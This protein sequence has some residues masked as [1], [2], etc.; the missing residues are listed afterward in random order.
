MNWYLPSLL[1]LLL[2]GI[3][4]FFYKV[5][6]ERRCSTAWVTFSFM[7][8]VMV[9]ST[10]LFFIQERQEANLGYLLA[11][12]FVNAAAFLMATV[13][14]IEAL[15][16]VPAHIA[17]TLIRMNVVVAAVFSLIYFKDHLSAVQGAGLIL[18]VAA[19]MILAWRMRRLPPSGS[20]DHRLRGAVFIGVAL[21][22]GATASISSKFA[23]LH[24][25]KLAFMAVSYL[26]GMI[27]SLGI[28]RAVP[29]AGKNAPNSQAVCLGIAMGLFNLGGFYA[30][31]LAL[32]TGP[33]SIIA[34]MVGMHFVISILLSAAIYRE[35]ISPAGLLG[36]LLTII[37]IV[38][39]RA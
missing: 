24:T 2:L 7:S 6:A 5:A 33:L 26:M 30:F 14:H 8:T 31:L 11:V 23:A 19:M 25:D 12:S 34:T 21:F 17:Y 10:A 18:A 16:D 1:A 27:G 36:L 20:A 13:A 28:N 22:A 37:S 32:E 3:Q 29:S 38:L 9:L 39:L 4:R 15:K 35:R